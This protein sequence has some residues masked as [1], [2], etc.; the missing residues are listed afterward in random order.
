MINFVIK[1]VALKD[2]FQDILR[3]E[4]PN[5]KKFRYNFVIMRFI[6]FMLLQELDLY[7]YSQFTIFHNCILTVESCLFQRSLNLQNDCR[8]FFRWVWLLYCGMSQQMCRTNTKNKHERSHRKQLQKTNN[9]LS[10]LWCQNHV[11]PHEKSSRHLPTR[12]H[13]VSECLWW[14]SGQVRGL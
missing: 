1:P 5:C 13:W 4:G 14:A 10:W 3:L 6:R 12:A 7:R 9:H 8:L 2:I 11:P